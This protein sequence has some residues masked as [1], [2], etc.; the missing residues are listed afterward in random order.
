VEALVQFITSNSQEPEVLGNAVRA[1]RSICSSDSAAVRQR[2]ADAGAVEALWQVISSNSQDPDMLGNAVR[3]LWSI[4]SSDSAAIRQRAA[5]AGAV[6]ALWQ[7]ISSNSQHSDG[8][9]AAAPEQQASSAAAGAPGSIAALPASSSG[10]GPAQQP[11][12]K[13]SGGQAL[14]PAAC[15]VCSSRGSKQHKLWLCRGCMA[16]RYCGVDCQRAHWPE[17]W[18]ECAAGVQQQQQCASS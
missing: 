14:P 4:C 16:V 12:D 17:H 15:T 2:A 1:L 10:G 11:A 7:V 6:E 9:Q 18:R 8:I 3:A 5:G 13:S